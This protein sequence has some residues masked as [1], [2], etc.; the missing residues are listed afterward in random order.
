VPV[1]RFARS[2]SLRTRLVVA[3]AGVIVLALALFATATVLVVNSQLRGSLDEALRQRAE[4]VAQLAIS[5]PGVLTHPGALESPVGGRQIAVEVI[6]ARGRILARSEALGAF[7][8]PEDRL[9]R[10][11][12]SLGRTGFEDV[13]VAGTQYRLFAAPIA[14]A[15]GPAAGG[16]VLVA[17]DT[18]DIT[19]AVSHLGVIIALIG[20]GAALLATFAA[21]M[22]TSRGL[23]PLRRLASGAAEIERTADP[24]RRLPEPARA[25]EI[26]ALTGVLNRMLA[27]LDRARASERRF[28]ADAS[29]ELRTPVTALRGN[30][31]YAMRHGANPEVLADLRDDADR[32]A[33]L[34]DDLLVLERA[35]AP[36]GLAPL[37]LDELARAAVHDRERVVLLTLEPAHVRGDEDALARALS[38]LIDNA[39]VH[40][41]PGGEVTVALRTDGGWALLTVSDEGPGPSDPERVFERFWRAPEAGGRPGSGLGLSIVQAIVE[42]HGGRVDVDGAAFTIGLPLD[43]VSV[44][45]LLSSPGSGR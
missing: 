15:G 25:D 23:R 11:A 43:A 2:L 14:Q 16:A 5:A 18:H 39:I 1:S 17:S 6:D 41:P 3:A 10:S 28:L 26:G 31:E 38:N 33:R 27:S 36:V 42:R 45:A 37:S 21:A 20:A 29:H 4:Q 24:A 13:R 40:G 35:S 32:L 8:L 34:V 19:H 7:L 30:V 12:I 22:L 44:P 9:A